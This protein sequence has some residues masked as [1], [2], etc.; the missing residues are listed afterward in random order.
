VSS[1][2]AAVLAAVALLAL[3]AAG[4]AAEPSWR[5]LAEAPVPRQEVTYVALGS[6]AYLT[7]GNERSQDRYDL[8]TDSW[9]PV[10][11]LPPAFEG[12][13]HVGGVALGDTIV[14]AGGLL[15]W[16]YPF[17]V[18][19][20]VAIYDPGTDSFSEG[21][22][23]PFPRAAGGV[24]AW[25]GLLVYAGGL[26]PAGSVTRVDAYDPADDSWT[27]LQNL[28]RARDHFQLVVA[29]G[30]LYAIGG[31]F[32]SEGSHGIRIEDI[33]TVDRLALPADPADLPDATWS[34]HVT[35][36]PTPRGGLGVTA[37][38]EC[39]Y[40]IGGE[41][42]GAA[43][44]GVTGVT[45]SYDTASG[46]W[47]ELPSLGTSRHGIEAAL[48]GHTILIA[49]GGLES[50]SDDPTAAQE[51]LDVS[52]ESPCVSIPPESPNTGSG[53]AEIPTGSPVLPVTRG[54]SAEGGSTG[55]AELRITRLSVR[56][57]R[58]QVGVAAHAT[59][60]LSTAGNVLF[61]VQRSEPLAG[62]CSARARRTRCTG[63][64]WEPTSW[65]ATRQLEAGRNVVPLRLAPPLPPGRYRLS[66]RALGPS[67]VPVVVRRGFRLVP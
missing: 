21:A 53:G 6:A 65:H 25:H 47:R 32:T 55:A 28:P 38:G 66:A 3:P 16:E 59:L 43:A 57:R 67:A 39:V 10:A 35:D 24:A 49:G 22:E 48:S 64:R 5:G 14:Y 44:P 2:R 34:A 30:A 13:D 18:A 40:A 29:G 45:E 62:P 17:P 42:E 54:R 37:V 56:P 12:L 52:G 50:F 23:M 63:G 33:E 36:L 46:T 60:V 31:R 9:Q 19:G 15:H 27:Q 1:A 8:L 61:R 4:A 26:G 11:P 51:A 20:P 7:A 58:V 41:V